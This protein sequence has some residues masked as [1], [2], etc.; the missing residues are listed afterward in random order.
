[1]NSE[2]PGLLDFWAEWCSPCLVIAPA[3]E[4]IAEACARRLKVGKSNFDE[5][6]AT[7]MRC[8]IWGIPTLLLFRGGRVIHPRGGA[9]G[10]S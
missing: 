7:E 10:R 8:R 1:M 5:N 9:A 3:V 6:G 4:A 2:L